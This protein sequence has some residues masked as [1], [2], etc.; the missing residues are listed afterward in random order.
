M[1]VASECRNELSDVLN[2]V[3]FVG[4][5]ND[6]KLLKNSASYGCTVGSLAESG[7]EVSQCCQHVTDVVVG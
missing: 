4:K 1:A 3:Q 2:G 7:G 6:Y 5:F